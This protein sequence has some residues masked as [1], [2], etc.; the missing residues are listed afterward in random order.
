MKP[1]L[2]RLRNLQQMDAA[3]AAIALCGMFLVPVIEVCLRPLQGSGIDNAPVLVQHLGLLF[4]LA[5]AIYAE[6]TGHLT[7]LGSFWREIPHSNARALAK[8]FVFLGS[9][10]VCGVLAE[11]SY[12]LVQTEIDT[13]HTIAYGIPTWLF[14]CAMPLGFT[15]LGFNLR[16]KWHTYPLLSWAGAFLVTALSWQASQWLTTAGIPLWISCLGL[17]VLIGLGGPVFLGLGGLSWI[18]FSSENIPMASLAL[19]HYQI[20]VN[21]SLPALPLFTL[22]V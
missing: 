14:L 9:A 2:Q 19:S 11:A 6:R 8:A 4:S 3:I 16:R 5:G 21:P 12:A 20:T 22:A 17:L 15:A 13:Q 10:L 1:L 18:L 7:S